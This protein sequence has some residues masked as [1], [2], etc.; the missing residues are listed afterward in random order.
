MDVDT[1]EDSLS[2]SL[3][4][5][6]ASGEFSILLSSPLTEGPPYEQTNDHQVGTPADSFEFS[7]ATDTPAGDGEFL[8]VSH[9]RSVDEESPIMASLNDLP[10]E[11]DSD[12]MRSQEA[13]VSEHS[14]THDEAS[15]T[16]SRG[17]SHPSNTSSIHAHS[18]GS[19]G[20]DA[21][22]TDGHNGNNGLRKLSQSWP[23]RDKVDKNAQNSQD[24]TTPIM[25]SMND[26]PPLSSPRAH[27]SAV[28]SG[29]SRRNRVEGVIDSVVSETAGV[30][31]GSRGIGDY[32][33]R[34]VESVVIQDSI[35]EPL[36]G[37]NLS[38][39]SDGSSRGLPPPP[40]MPF[41][42][43]PAIGALKQV[44]CHF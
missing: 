41:S 26:L 27:G 32:N 43:L 6:G 33:V 1:A 37:E 14:H 23:S 2:P 5:L 25:A 11:T 15:R 22:R 13:K 29:D 30:K 4:E 35:D 31:I 18:L 34:P 10:Q 8:L 20:S 7:P 17:R 16:S 9:R 21:A 40:T 12:R 42:P 24:I 36:L 39:Y 38:I 44:S 28:S 19:D 3:P